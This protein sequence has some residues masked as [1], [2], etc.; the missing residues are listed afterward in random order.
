LHLPGGFA[1][2][3]ASGVAGSVLVA[4]SDVAA[5]AV[6]IVRPGRGTG[7]TEKEVA[8]CWLWPSR[9]PTPPAPGT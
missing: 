1:L 9:P 8:P 5:M 6:T 3:A 2:L 4:L 7:S